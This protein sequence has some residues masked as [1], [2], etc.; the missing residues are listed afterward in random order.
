MSRYEFYEIKSKKSLQFTNG[1]R[2]VS[3]VC[4]G[5]PD[6]HIFIWLDQNERIKHL[7]FLF[8][9]KIIEWFDERKELLTS[10]TNRGMNGQQKPGIHKGV[11]TIHSVKDDSIRREGLEIL[12]EA[13]FPFKYENAIKKI[14]GVAAA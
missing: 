9:E 5:F 3:L 13:V 7:Q 8:N 4:S 1:L 14:M 12:T 10:Q 2:K 6:A 11:R